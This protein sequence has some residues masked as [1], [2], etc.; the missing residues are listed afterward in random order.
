MEKLFYFFTLGDNDLKPY[1]TTSLSRIFDY[2]RLKGASCGLSGLTN[3]EIKDILESF[4]PT[5]VT[6]IDE[7]TYRIT[8]EGFKVYQRMKE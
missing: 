8:D 6:K 4:V 3:D 7:F 2:I 5:Y 1:A